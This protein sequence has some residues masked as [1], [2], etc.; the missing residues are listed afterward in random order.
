MMVNTEYYKNLLKE[1]KDKEKRV[2]KNLFIVDESLPGKSQLFT[3]T[4][5]ETVYFLDDVTPYETL[6][7]HVKRLGIDF[8]KILYRRKGS[9]TFCRFVDGK[10]KPIT[11]RS[12][13][14]RELMDK[15][16]E[17]NYPPKL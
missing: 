16:A 2:R 3:S 15:L 12:E 1:L 9:K 4:S 11:K 13:G 8:S 6:L 7:G 14:Y 10:W 17:I 5:G